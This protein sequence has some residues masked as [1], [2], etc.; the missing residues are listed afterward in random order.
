MGVLLGGGSGLMQWRSGWRQCLCPLARAD[1]VASAGNQLAAVDNA[2]HMLWHAGRILPCD[3]DVEALRLWKEYALLLSSD[4]DCLSAALPDGWCV[5]AKSGLYPQDL[6]IEGDEALVC[7]GMDGRLKR[8]S[9]PELYMLEEYPVPG[10]PERV[11]VCDGEA[12]V[13]SLLPEEP[14]RSAFVLLN[15]NTGK[16]EEITRLSGLPGALCPGGEGV[17]AAAGNSLYYYPKGAS[18]PETSFEGF[19]LIRHLEARA[20]SVLLTDTL[21]GICA[22]AVQRGEP[23]LHVLYRGEIGQACMI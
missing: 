18:M 14:V 10:L 15:L 16:S 3:R 5:T 22:M 7:G 20:N 1:L 23:S 17:W 9:L 2:A 6:W 4:T 11:C 12:Y 13:L 19:G 8:M 21:E